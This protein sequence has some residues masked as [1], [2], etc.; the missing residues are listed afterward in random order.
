MSKFV[1]VY[2]L[3]SQ[4][5]PGRHYTGLT[6]DLTARL[7][8]HNTGNCPHTSKFKPWQIET[9]VAFRSRE[10]AAAFERYLKSSSGR[11]FAIRHF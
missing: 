7:V 6:D 5:H 4:S 3:T 10:K 8:R 2:V 1:Y 11:A 9:A